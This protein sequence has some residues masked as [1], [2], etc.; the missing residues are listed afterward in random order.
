MKEVHKNLWVGDQSD[1][2]IIEPN[3]R[4]WM[5]LHAAKEP[6]HR[7]FVG[8]S[9]RGAPKDSPEYLWALRGNRLALNLEKFREIYPA[10]NPA[11]GMMGFIKAS[12]GE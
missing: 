2:L 6:W 4:D 5:V 9:G 10:F 7:E 3:S 1:W 11:G 12:L 8:Y